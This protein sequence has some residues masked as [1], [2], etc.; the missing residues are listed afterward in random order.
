[1]L[2]I[3]FVDQNNLFIISWSCINKTKAIIKVRSDLHL[4]HLPSTCTPLS[5]VCKQ[6]NDIC[7][8]YTKYNKKHQIVGLGN[9]RDTLYIF[10]EVNHNL[11]TQ[12]SIIITGLPT[13]TFHMQCIGIFQRRCTKVNQSIPDCTAS[14]WQPSFATNYT[15]TCYV[16]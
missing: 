3:S 8:I 4:Y 6:V 2:Q 12:L 5:L 10:T 9:L 14:Y 7:H 16:M 13:P 1:M 15:M 11:N